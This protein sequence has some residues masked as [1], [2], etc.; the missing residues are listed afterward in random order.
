MKIERFARCEETD[1]DSF[2]VDYTQMTASKRKVC[3]IH[4]EPDDILNHAY[5]KIPK[6]EI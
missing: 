6:E 3:I 4:E 5:I 1:G 2:V